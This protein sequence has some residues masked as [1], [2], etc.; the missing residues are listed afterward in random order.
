MACFLKICEQH[1]ISAAAQSFFMTPQAVSKEVKRMEEELG[2]PL[3]FRSQKGV[4]PTE[5]G[6]GLSS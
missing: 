5:Y 1:S 4:V 3:L 2:A 6:K